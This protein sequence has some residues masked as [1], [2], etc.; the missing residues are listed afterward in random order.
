VAIDLCTEAGAGT[1]V[2]VGLSADELT[3]KAFVF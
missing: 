1:L 2:L 3:S